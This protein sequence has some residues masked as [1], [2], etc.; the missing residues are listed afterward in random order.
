MYADFNIDALNI[1]NLGQ[2]Y[3]LCY[4]CLNLFW[5]LMFD[6]L[7]SSVHIV[8][9]VTAFDAATLKPYVL[10]RIQIARGASVTPAHAGNSQARALSHHGGAGGSYGSVLTIPSFKWLVQKRYSHFEELHSAL[11]SECESKSSSSYV[12]H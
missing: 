8:G 2:K 12:L 9:A 7:L 10:Y 4:F 5:L 1:F 11:V 3:K 6:C